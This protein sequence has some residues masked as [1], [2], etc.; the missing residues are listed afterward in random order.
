M[1]KNIIFWFVSLLMLVGLL[2]FWLYPNDVSSSTRIPTNKNS[3]TKELK[4]YDLGLNPQ[5]ETVYQEFKYVSPKFPNEN[6]LKLIGRLGNGIKK[7][8]MVLIK[9][10][11]LFHCGER[12]TKEEDIEEFAMLWAYHIVK[13]SWEAER[14]L[15]DKRRYYVNPWGVAGT[16]A[17]ESSFDLCALG[18]NPRRAAY[19]LKDRNGKPVLKKRKTGISHTR[20]EVLSA[21]NNRQ[22][23]K[24]FKVFDLGGLQTLTKYWPGHPKYLLTWEGFYFQ[25]ALMAKRGWQ[26]KTKRPWS[27]WRGRYTLW[28]DKKVTRRARKLGATVTDLP[29]PPLKARFL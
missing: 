7:F 28:Y 2:S 3:I 20:E 8:K 4:S 18:L 25:V 17:N 23:K 5:K 19:E 6:Q 27:Y 13:A 14:N 24:R 9:G 1:K 22:L 12:I 21:I 15:G 26:Y 29:W 11:N 16:V 10:G